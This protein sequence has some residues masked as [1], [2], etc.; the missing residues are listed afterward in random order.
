LQGL[1][2]RLKTVVVC[3]Y[4]LNPGYSEKTATQQ[5][6]PVQEDQA[7]VF[8]DYKIGLFNHKVHVTGAGL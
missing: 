4:F 7:V 3:C 1:P 6:A 8:P 2:G 5:K